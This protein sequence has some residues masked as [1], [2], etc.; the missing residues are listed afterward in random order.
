MQRH[1]LQIFSFTQMADVVQGKSRG[2][3]FAEEQLKRQG[4]KHGEMISRHLI[5]VDSCRFLIRSTSPSGQ[6][7]G[8]AQNGISEALKVKV[9]CGKGGVSNPRSVCSNVH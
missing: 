2:L 9:K 7:L 8:R 4:W 3:K 1:S 5:C 6:G